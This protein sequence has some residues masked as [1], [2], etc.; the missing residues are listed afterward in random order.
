MEK[1]QFEDTEQTSELE[2]Y[3]SGMFKLSEQEFLKTMINMLRVITEESK[4]VRT[5][6]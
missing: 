3:I 1:N 2:L 4:H 6:G 5:E